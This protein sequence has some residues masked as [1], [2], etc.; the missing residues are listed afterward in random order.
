M[1]QFY[2]PAI[3]DELVRRGESIYD[4]L[5]LS[6]LETV[7]AG[8]YVA[9]HVDSGDFACARSTAEATRKLRRRHPADG[10]IFLRQI[11]EE[12]DFGLAARLLAGQIVYTKSTQRLSDLQRQ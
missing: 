4:S 11:G 10:R 3:M 9:I 2:Q 8:R 7:R 12:P 1:P 5:K 6:L